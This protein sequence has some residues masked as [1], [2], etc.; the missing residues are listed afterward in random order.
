MRDADVRLIAWCGC[1]GRSASGVVLEVYDLSGHQLW[2]MMDHYQAGGRYRVSW[3][4]LDGAD[5]SLS[6]GVYLMRLKALG[7]LETRKMIADEAGP[8]KDD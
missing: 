8:V 7:H 5:D 4:G 6:N 3:D 1:F 2:H